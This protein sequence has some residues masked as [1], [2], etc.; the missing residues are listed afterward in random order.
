MQ[1]RP[2]LS[3]GVV[4][5]LSA[6]AA[7]PV[8]QSGPQPTYGPSQTVEY[9]GTAFQTKL[10]AGRPGK[11]LTAQGAVPA[12]G[13]SVV[14]A[15]FGPDQGRMAKDVARLACEGAAGRFQPRAVGRFAAGA[16]VFEG[17]CA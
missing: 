15:P 11:V 2:F 8:P 5:G 12:P 17:G 14:V 1:L 4:A 9:R 13:L 16:W 10:I 6:C 7:A 3:M